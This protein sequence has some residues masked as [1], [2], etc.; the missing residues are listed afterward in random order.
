MCEAAV[1]LDPYEEIS[2]ALARFFARTRGR[3]RTFEEH[4]Q[5]LIRERR[6]IDAL[7]VDF[8]R[9]AADLSASRKWNLDSDWTGP[10]AWLTNMCHLRPVEAGA[11]LCVGENASQLERSI[12]K[13][14]AGTIGYAHL[15]LMARTSDALRESGATLDE[16]RLLRRAETKTPHE[17]RRICAHARHAADAAAFHARQ[18]EGA[19][20]RFL[21]VSS[22]GG[23]DGGFWIR[24]F[25][26]TV[27]GTALKAALAPLSRRLDG[28]DHRPLSQRLGDALV[29]MSMYTLNTGG[30]GPTHRQVPHLQITASVET[31]AGAAGAP[32]GELDGSVPISAATVERF[33]CSANVRR[34]LLDSESLPF[35]VG[36]ERRLPST[37]TRVKVEHRDRG[38]V[39]P[40]CTRTVRWTD[41]HH[42]QHW[43]RD[44]GATEDGN[45][46]CLCWR[47]HDD[48][49]LRGWR[50]M[51]VAGQREVVTIPPIPPA[52]C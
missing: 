24:G 39:W 17:F 49:H 38:C 20:G 26:D 5:H 6:V 48:V 34:I 40:R 21:E 3:Q 30:R 42:V 51:R 36:R 46:V 19:D 7:Q 18:Q 33:S 12:E 41:I 37:A 2:A 25:L 8:A 9:V 47:H 43:T 4:E 31:L 10:I 32:A 35:D 52:D 45:L 50:I 13:V 11:A 16:A 14:A 29:E 44:H 1:E 22:C 15:V 27:G 28:D 23:D